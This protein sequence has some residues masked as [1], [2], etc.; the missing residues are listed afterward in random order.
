MSRLNRTMIPVMLFLASAFLFG[1]ALPGLLDMGSGR[2]ASL[3]SLYGFQIYE[4]SSIEFR[5]LFFYI[6]SVRL[7]TLLIL[8]L[9][10]FTAIGLLFHL[11]YGWWLTASGAMLLS[12]FGM[13]D[14]MEGVLHFGF[15]I[16]PQWIFY[17]ILWKKEI[18]F[19]L[20]RQE[21]WKG[22]PENRGFYQRK[23]A[24]MPVLAANL[25]E[26]LSLGAICILGCACEAFLGTWMLQL[27][28]RL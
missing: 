7:R 16:F 24:F 18:V 14:G 4:N 23:G 9:S 21:Q 27:Y 13:R 19:W 2:Y 20:R 3:A 15:C 25:S 28:L 8:W 11:G 12:L 1:S 6:T 17:S 5:N 26:M 10:S 22:Q